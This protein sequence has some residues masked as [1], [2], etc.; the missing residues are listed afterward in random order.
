MHDQDY[1]AVLQV[2]KDAT[3]QEI[4]SAFRRLARQYH[5]DLNPNNLASEEK[6]RKI[7]EAYEVLCD[8]LQRHQYDQKFDNTR[9]HDTTQP[10]AYQDFYVRGVEKALLKNYQAALDNY[11]QA[12]RLNPNF[13]D[14]YLKRCEVR[15]QLRD[16]RGVLNDCHHILMIDSYSAQAYYY[17]GRSRWRLGYSQAA[18]EAYTQAINCNKDY[19]QAYYYRGLV[20]QE[21]KSYRQA[22]YDLKNAAELFQSQADL[23]GYKLAREALKKVSGGNFGAIIITFK[24][25]KDVLETTLKTLMTFILNPGGGLL[26]AFTRLTAKE[27]ILA[28][29]L[30]GAIANFCFVCKFYLDWQYF[31][32][33]TLFQSVILGIMPFVSLFFL[34]RIIGLLFPNKSSYAADIFLSGTTLLPFSFLAL[35]SSFVSSLPSFV[36]TIITIFAGCHTIF[37]LYTGCTQIH[38]ISERIAT[39]LVPIMLFLAFSPILFLLSS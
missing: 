28:G 19:A 17:Q 12:I 14:A 2:S 13:L 5:P 8:S 22:S 38:N 35:I 15:Y 21:L 29:I 7:C 4:K 20:N 23:S 34:S 36:M 11:N 33:L 37:I 24:T 30:Y 26:P 1:Y 10:L 32:R 27:A 3:L 18:I 25:I 16:D 9:Y 39:F 6:F 31:L